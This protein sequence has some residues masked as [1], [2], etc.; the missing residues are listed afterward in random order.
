MTSTNS[1]GNGA[2]SLFDFEV[3]D[4]PAAAGPSGGEPRRR[5]SSRFTTLNNR[6]GYALALIAILAPIPLASNRPSIWMLW[7]L[8]ICALWA[9]YLTA[10]SVLAPDRPL[11]LRWLKWPLIVALVVPGFAL[12]QLL[13]ISAVLPGFLA[14]LPLPKALH[15][16]TLSMAPGETVYGAVRFISYVGFFALVLEVSARRDRARKIGWLL[17]A[18]V[19]LHAF[20]AMISLTMLGD[21]ILFQEKL[22]YRGSATGTFVNRNSFATFLAMGGVLGIAL[23]MEAPHDIRMRRPRPASLLSPESLEK[24]FR[25]LLVALVGLTLLATRSRL[26]LAA[27][28]F[29]VTATWLLFA[30]KSGKTA[31]SLGVGMLL[32]AV[33]GGSAVLLFGQ[34]TVE[35]LLYAQGDSAGRLTLYQQV[36]GMI[37]ER[38]LTG[39]GLGAF[40][41]AF[42][43]FHGVDLSTGAYWN[44][45]H[46]TYLSNWVE[47]GLIVGSAPLLAGA[48]V[49]HRLQR[50]IRDR[51]RDYG[52]AIAAIGALIVGALHSVADFSLEIQANTFLLLAIVGIGTAHRRTRLQSA[53]KT[54]PRVIETT[55]AGGLVSLSTKE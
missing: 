9:I 13:P 55:D 12:L 22:A 41:P 23:L 35:R 8:V 6:I 36:L 40:R 5:A 4:L 28:M 19:A 37:V 53:S 32:I 18:G 48:L 51:D 38:P 44:S 34:G 52:L 43:P 1:P 47:L 50:Q 20:W 2:P 7:G 17:F 16:A 11:Q 15:P 46:S 39:Y 29:G 3:S 33:I 10:A 24:G 27:G 25:W 49:I 31:Q 26:G 21:T 30:L 14:G 42:E 54:P 45:A